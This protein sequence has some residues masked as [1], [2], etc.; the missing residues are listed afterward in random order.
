METLH[1]YGHLAGFLGRITSYIMKLTLR[2]TLSSLAIFLLT[3]LALASSA[4][5]NLANAHD[6]A[7]HAVLFHSPNCGYCKIVIHEILPPIKAEYGE[8]LQILE[9]NVTLPV[10]SELHHEAVE[11]YQ[12][13]RYGVPLLVI[14]DQ[15]LIGSDQIAE[16]LPGLIEAGLQNDGIPWPPI[17]GLED[18]VAIHLEATRVAQAMITP[19]SGAF[20][21]P[22]S[23]PDLQQ[24]GLG[25]EDASLVTI[26]VQRFQRDLAGN[27][28]AVIILAAMLVSI[29]SVGYTFV[30]TTE[31]EDLKGTL[32]GRTWPKWT[33]PVLCLLGLGVAGYLSF[34]EVTNTEAVCGPVGDC[35]TVQESRYAT[36]W[37]VIP[38]GV[39][40]MIGYIAILAA[41]AVNQ[42]APPRWHNPSAIA[43]WVMALIGTLFSIY[44]TFLEPFV[45]GATCIWCIASAILITMVMWVTARPALIALAGEHDDGDLDDLERA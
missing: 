10:G 43:M 23:V 5:L 35:N 34:V 39:F 4:N 30:N 22:V 20:Q 42:Y 37:G 27:T 41:W 15:F 19:A 36:L 31:P 26:V 3:L 25:E 28:L 21:N 9:V 18:M 24:G 7:V 11:L 45:I 33:V 14:G 2:K 12:V 32:A 6:A 38:V 29:G 8:H 13:G 40:G 17:P 16:Q 44:L 1:T